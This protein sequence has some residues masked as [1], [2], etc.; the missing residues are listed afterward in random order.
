MKTETDS[1]KFNPQFLVS[2]EEVAN[3]LLDFRSFMI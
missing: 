2:L 1:D 3:S